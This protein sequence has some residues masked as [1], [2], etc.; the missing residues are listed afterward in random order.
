[1]QTKYHLGHRILLDWRKKRLAR[2]ELLL[3]EQE[4]SDYIGKKFDYFAGMVLCWVLAL[5]LSSK[6]VS[7]SLA[8]V[9]SFAGPIAF[10]YM[11]RKSVLYKQKIISTMK[12]ERFRKNNCLANLIAA[13][14]YQL[15]QLNLQLA[16]RLDLKNLVL[17][18]SGLP[19]LGEKN[20]KKVGLYLFATKDKKEVDNKELRDAIALIK[21]QGAE[22]A[23]F[24]SAT[25]FSEEAENVQESYDMKIKLVD[26]HRLATLLKELDHPF[27]TSKEEEIVEKRD[28][29]EA[30]ADKKLVDMF[31][32]R[33]ALARKYLIIA[34]VLIGFSVVM[35]GLVKALYLVLAGI[36]VALAL[37]TYYRHLPDPQEDK[38]ALDDI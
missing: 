34:L 14:Q 22:G 15:D 28:N 35:S 24:F 26:R 2:L 23:V 31:V 1:M 18:Q 7:I 32:E 3:E 4:N 36:N 10:S 37:Y 17:S 19:V 29:S 5:I 13:E 11:Y 9:I 16:E 33:P 6:L 20:G 21:Q 38:L 30:K 12:Q 27:Y 25:G 8:L